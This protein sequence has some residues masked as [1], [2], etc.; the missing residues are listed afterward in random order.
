MPGSV[1]GPKS[2]IAPT[3][4]DADKRAVD[5]E[6]AVQ[7]RAEERA[8]RRQQQQPQRFTGGGT[9]EGRNWTHDLLKDSPMSTNIEDRR[10]EADATGD[11]KTRATTDLTDEIRKL[12]AN[13]LRGVGESFAAG[14]G[15]A[16]KFAPSGGDGDLRTGT[17]PGGGPPGG[18]IPGGGPRGGGGG[19]R[20]GPTI[21]SP[22]IPPQ[23]VPVYPRGESKAAGKHLGTA[24]DATMPAPGAEVPVYG[25]GEGKA[26]GKR[27]GTAPDATMP[28]PEG[29]TEG[30]VYG[31]Q[32][33]SNL[34]IPA[35]I[36]Y[37]NPGAQAFAPTARKWSGEP[38]TTGTGHLIAG[39]PTPVHGL[40]SNIDLLNRKYVGR[41]IGDAMWEWSGNSRCTVGPTVGAYPPNMILT[42][43]MAEDPAF[44]AAMHGA[45]SGRKGGL[46]PA[47][48]Q[49]ALDM[50]R[51][52]SA[53]AYEKDNP[54]FVKQYKGRMQQA[55]TQP[56][57]AA[58]AA[59]STP[60]D[61]QPGLVSPVTGTF[62]GHPDSP[63]GA[64]R[65]GG[66][67]H[68][69]VDWQ[70]ADDSDAVAMQDGTVLYTGHNKGYQHNIVIKHAD[71]TITRYATHGPLAN[72]KVGDT[73]KQG[74]TV[75]KIDRRHL[76]LEHIPQ[77]L[78]DGKTINPKWQEFHDNAKSN[79]F[80]STS[81]QKGTIDPRQYTNL[82]YSAPVKAGAPLNPNAPATA[83]RDAPPDPY[84][85]RR[86]AKAKEAA[87]TAADAPDPG[88]P[89]AAG[90]NL[91]KQATAAPIT[92]D[93]PDEGGSKAAG[94]NLGKTTADIDGLQ[95][96][97]FGKKGMPY[98][99]GEGGP[100]LFMPFQ[101]GMVLPNMAMKYLKGL[102]IG[103]RSLGEYFNMAQSPGKMLSSVFGGGSP[104][105]AALGGLGGGGGGGG[106]GGNP[107]QTISGLMGFQE[108][109]AVDMWGRP[110]GPGA[111]KPQ[112]PGYAEWENAP[113][114]SEMEGGNLPSPNELRL[115]EGLMEDQLERRGQE[116]ELGLE[117]R[118]QQDVSLP[119]SL[120]ASRQAQKISGER[121]HR[122]QYW[123]NGECG[124]CQGRKIRVV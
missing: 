85:A 114:L 54:D 123:V 30:A 28:A 94:K 97:G 83:S 45:E 18:T 101:S 56:P 69:G 41:T 122:Y 111:S 14:T 119:G 67:G 7:R 118:Y 88:G 31:P 78:A 20:R 112:L 72:L 32:D 81:H 1:L 16:V 110:V 38:G 108:G 26:A 103:G 106:E 70:A 121:K 5:L 2:S 11:E 71:G 99:V 82:P 84:Y 57:G 90:K 113:A 29:A 36:R 68:S 98:I 73:V 93:K 76:H 75:G 80:T 43:E 3:P 49:Q 89:K 39:F 42:K 27:L 58:P 15:G 10:R 107:L 9:I 116:L 6:G 50:Y 60:G 77:F 53:A 61:G 37:N 35:S 65:G 87:S 24:P 17:G 44:W 79:A 12:N 22:V 34:K 4:E 19:T 96:G 74:Q 120:Y 52:G 95:A 48:V 47:Q 109:G 25:P 66:R 40:A 13:F 64:G 63:Y 55:T 115:H 59:A 86:A 21:P 102:Q 51:A 100:E 33:R 91:G 62:G 105:T 124:N 104:L 92:V 8:R 46:T 23:P 117:K